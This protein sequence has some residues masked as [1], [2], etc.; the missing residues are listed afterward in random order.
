[1]IGLKDVKFK[2]ELKII[3]IDFYKEL[4]EREKNRNNLK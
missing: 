2:N 3:K 4:T 1:M